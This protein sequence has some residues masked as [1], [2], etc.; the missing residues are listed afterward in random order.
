M[1]I[2]VEPVNARPYWRNYPDPK[3]RRKPINRKR[4]ACTMCAKYP[5]FRG[6]ENISTNLAITC[7]DFK[8]SK[9]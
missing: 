4:V 2:Y 9:V 1:M 7:H 3:P 6:L 8:K 5:C